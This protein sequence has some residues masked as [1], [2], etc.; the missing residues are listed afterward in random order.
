MLKRLG[1][2]FGRFDVRS[3][4]SQ[5]EPRKVVNCEAYEGFESAALTDTPMLVLSCRVS[6]CF[7]AVVLAEHSKDGG[8]LFWKSRPGLALNRWTGCERTYKLFALHVFAWASEIYGFGYGWL[9]R[10]FSASGLG[11]GKAES[12][13]PA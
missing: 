9:Q 11:A 7:R 8:S 4:Y 3:A 2:R 5:G 10:G 13:L 6:F 12:R 1:G